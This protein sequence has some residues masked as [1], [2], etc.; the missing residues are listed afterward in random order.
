MCVRMSS[1][2]V[3]TVI[4]VARV[5]GVRYS[6]FSSEFVTK[7]N[8]EVF[9]DLNMHQH[10]I[11][12]LANGIATQ[13]AVN[14]QQLNSSTASV[15]VGSEILS[16]NTVQ[17]VV[18]IN[19]YVYSGT[20][21]NPETGLAVYRS[22]PAGSNVL[23]VLPG[24]ASNIAGV[25]PTNWQGFD[26]VFPTVSGFAIGSNNIAGVNAGIPPSIDYNCQL[27]CLIGGVLSATAV[28]CVFNKLTGST[29]ADLYF[30]VVPTQT[31]YN[32]KIPGIGVNSLLDF[33]TSLVALRFFVPASQ[34]ATFN[35]VSIQ[36]LW[37][38]YTA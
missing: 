8:P 11:V 9:G 27:K 37:L 6:E 23:M 29:I 35:D 15:V 14:L 5:Y 31:T 28:F 25:Q 7:A 21:I 4:G 2:L 16:T 10:R 36:K 1:L 38:T 18:S 30:D 32:L 33:E 17:S 22:Q 19:D 3:Q 34:T 26:T 20:P 12:N 13:D 24:F